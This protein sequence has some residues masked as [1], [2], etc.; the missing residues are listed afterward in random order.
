[1]MFVC[2]SSKGPGEMSDIN[3]TVSVQVYDR[4]DKDIY[5]IDHK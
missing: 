4:W 2:V 3:F 5:L 1:M